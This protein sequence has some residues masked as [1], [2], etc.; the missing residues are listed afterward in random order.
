MRE[1]GEE[2]VNLTLQQLFTLMCS[3]WACWVVV[4]WA[5]R[6]RGEKEGNAHTESKWDTQTLRERVTQRMDDLFHTRLF[7]SNWS[8][9][10][11]YILWSLVEQLFSSSS[12]S[13]S[14][15]PSHFFSFTQK[16]SEERWVV[17]VRWDGQGMNLAWDLSREDSWYQCGWLL[18]LLWM[19]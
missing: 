8:V 1:R 9:E 11:E 14:S 17:Q 13:F 19:K 15:S 2:E 6:E 16:R 4:S 5:L 12:S 18:L 3:W 7:I 10:D